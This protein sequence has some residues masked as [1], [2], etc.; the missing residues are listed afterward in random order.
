[1]RKSAAISKE[2]VLG[3]HLL[4]LGTAS[5]AASSAILLG[6]SP[7]LDLLLMA[8]L[9]TLGAYTMNRSAEMDRDVLSNP[10]RTHYLWGRRRYLPAIAVSCFALGYLLAALRNLT[11]FTAL[12]IPLLLSITYSAGSKKLIPL[13]GVKTL[14]EKPIVKNITISLGW[15]LIP[16]LVGLYYQEISFELYLFAVFI[17]LRLMVNT[18]FFDIRD[19]EGDSAAGVKTMP[20]IYGRKR[21]LAVITLIDIL[22]AAY[23]VSALIL[24]LLPAYSIMVIAFPIYSISYRW[25]AQRPNANINLLCDVV[26]DGEYLLWGPVIFLGRI[27]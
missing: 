1:M 17:F 16:V 22:S 13:L 19:L 2:M 20:T 24:K 6:G 11:F 10:S 25:L 5:I 15:S 27:L 23:I 14:K 26:A 3:G 18:I 12:L 4:A 8:Y 7:G 9:F 21:S